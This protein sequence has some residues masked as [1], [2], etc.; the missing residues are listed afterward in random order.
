MIL[1][2][3]ACLIVGIQTPNFIEQYEKRIDAHY[4]EVT[5]NLRGFQEVADRFHG[6]S[7]AALIVKH[8][9]SPDSTFK[10]EAEPIER[11]VAR[12]DRFGKEREALRSSYPLKVAHTLMRGDREILDETYAGYSRTFSLDKRALLS[13]L[14]AAIAICF[15][16]E[17]FFGLAKRLLGFKG[18]RNPNL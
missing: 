15:V 12:R 6:G 5:E 18:P 14:G 7:L 9:S 13:G 10:G 3:G 11:M 2:F 1:V 16:L 4:R 8:R 17:M